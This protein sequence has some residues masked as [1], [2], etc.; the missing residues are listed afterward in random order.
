VRAGAGAATAAELIIGVVPGCGGMFS[1]ENGEGVPFLVRSRLFTE[2]E[3][4]A[5]KVQGKV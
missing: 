1:L 5:L 4:A 2:E 3:F